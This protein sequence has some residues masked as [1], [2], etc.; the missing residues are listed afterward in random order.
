MSKYPEVIKDKEDSDGF[1]VDWNTIEKEYRKSRHRHHRHHEDSPVNLDE[2]SDEN[3]PKKKKR[4]KKILIGILI[5]L[6]LLVVSLVSA[7]FILRYIGK[8]NL[9]T[10]SLDM[11][12]PEF[13]DDYK[14][15]GK[16]LKYKGHT[17]QFNENLS[18]ILF[19]GIDNTELKENAIAGTAGQADALYLLLYDIKSGKIRTLAINRDTM[20]DIN[21]YN[22]IGDYAGTINQQLCLA[23]AYGDGKNKSAENQVRS[24][25]RLLY[26]IP[27]NAY[28]AIDL[29]AIKILND[30]I[31]GV[32]LTP[33]YTF[34]NFTKGQ[35][36]TL[37][38][39]MA[40]TF[41]RSRNKELLDDNLRR[42][43]CQKQYITGFANQIVPAIRNDFMVPIN[44]YNDASN[45]T[46]SNIGVPEMVFLSSTLAANY[47][48]LDIV[49]TK[50]EYQ[51]NEGDI[52]AEYFLDQ[53][54][55]FE[56]LLDLFYIKID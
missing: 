10:Q 28:F 16:I 21:I 33:N 9:T 47:S 3:N 41:V 29:S 35:T 6:I 45:Y 24:V 11:D 38:G 36:V 34:A 8:K 1:E 23:Y 51:L 2:N 20:V 25:E 31:G 26:N 42:I 18:S 48:G 37:K 4:T 54:A 30:D 44:L 53:E 46:V 14:D 13:V 27:V 39:D 15:G 52:S 40:E 12:I 49:G 50:G 32:S 19:M 5:F 22:E 17:Y 7:F 55:F 56:T 43:E